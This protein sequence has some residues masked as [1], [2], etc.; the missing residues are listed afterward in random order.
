MTTFIAALVLMWLGSGTVKGFAYTLI[1]SLIVSMFTALVISRLLNLAFYAVG[2]RNEKLYGRAKGRCLGPIDFMKHRWVC[3]ILSLVVI[4]AGFVGMIGY[5]A[6]GKGALNF[7]LEFKGGTS[8]SADFGKDY[9]VEQVE[10]Q[11]LYRK[12]QRL[13]MIMPS[14]QV[15]YPAAML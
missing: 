9:T 3:F 15:P 14:R 5:G 7:S 8:I 1:I 13:S 2:C 10:D 12:S 4:V 11:R 6:A